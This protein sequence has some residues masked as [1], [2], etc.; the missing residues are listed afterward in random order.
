M[1]EEESTDLLFKQL[2]VLI[3]QYKPSTW[4]SRKATVKWWGVTQYFGYGNDRACFLA[5][6]LWVQSE[7]QGSHNTRSRMDLVL[8]VLLSQPGACSQTQP[9]CNSTSGSFT[10]FAEQHLREWRKLHSNS[11]RFGFQCNGYFWST[12]RSPG[13]EFPCIFSSG[14]R[15]LFDLFCARG[16]KGGHG[17]TQNLSHHEYPGGKA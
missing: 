4:K 9:T 2:L 10:G 8:W 5:F 17:V 14:S 3:V 16:Q 7:V 12:L 11:V 15:R 6:P 13:T 1:G